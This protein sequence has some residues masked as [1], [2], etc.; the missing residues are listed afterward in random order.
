MRMIKE[1]F[2]L[3]HLCGMSQKQIAKA[4]G[5]ARGTVSEYLH[6]GEVA[7]F[8]WPLP[9]EL[10]DAQIE[11]RLFPVREHSRASRPEPDWAYIH[12]ELKKKGVTSSFTFA[13]LFW[14]ETVES[15]CNGHASAF[16]YFD[17]CPR[18]VVPDNP[19]PVVTK[20]CPYEPDINPSF[21][22]MA[23]HYSVAVMPARV[24]RPKDKDLISGFDINTISVTGVTVAVLM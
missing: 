14:D 8:T 23:A 13:D 10:D 4:L 11:Q 7:G 18:I 9:D 5:C 19:K 20:T 24:R 2:R 12:S 15:W 6:R 3:Y 22:Q 17:G 16:D 1:I 21:A